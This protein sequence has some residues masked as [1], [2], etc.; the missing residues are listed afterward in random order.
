MAGAVQ[1]TLQLVDRLTA[2]A[3]N[4]QK[5]LELVE[6]TIKRVEAATRLSGGAFGGWAKAGENSA[7]RVDAA[8]KRVQNRVG[9]TQQGFQGLTQMLGTAGFAVAGVGYGV[10]YA[11]KSIVDAAA[12]KQN[13]LLSLRGMMEGDASRAAKLFEDAQRFA[14][15]TPFTTREILDA[16]RQSVA[17]GF[18]PSQAIPL[19]ELAGKLSVGSGKSMDQV[20][21]AF[22]ALRGGD[23]GQ[24]FGV[25]QGFSNLNISRMALKAA[26]LKFGANGE[27]KGTI[28]E[29]INAVSKIINKQ[30]G[31][32]LKEQSS[33]LS[34]LA[35]T[36]ASRPEE[37]FMSLVDSKGSSRAL[38]P[39]Q[40]FM[41]NLAE[42]TDFSKGPGSRI[43]KRF[44]KSM[45]GLFGAV[46]NPLADA[47]GGQKG[48][49]TINRI[50]SKLDDYATWWER[51]G[52][53][54]IA[55]AKGFGEG[56]AAGVNTALIPVKLLGASLDKLDRL[57][58]GEGSGGMGKVLGFMVG[59]GGVAWLANLLSFG[60]I[61]KL[62][63]KGGQMLIGA[64]KTGISRAGQAI[65]GRSWLA[66][67][68]MGS[69]RGGGLLA[70][71]GLK[72]LGPK[73]LGGLKTL[74]PRMLGWL[75]RLAPLAARF[76]PWL[77]RIGALF[78]GL[79]NPIG[80]VVT[81]VT[82]IAGLGAIL[83]RKWEPFRDF[84]DG[85]GDGFRSAADSA[86]RWF[87]SIPSR[88]AGL[89]ATLYETLLPDWVRDGL[90]RIG[91][92]L[93][94]PQ[95]VQQAA[96]AVPTGPQPKTPP[97]T[98]TG[99]NAS[100]SALTGVAER[101]GIDPQ[102]LLAVAFKESA[103]NPAAVNKASG[104]SGL[105][106]FL[107]STARGLGTTAEAVRR[108]SPTEQAPYIERYLRE[109]GVRPGASLEQVYAAVFAGSA[110]KTGRVLYTTADGRAYSDN[111][112]LDL[113]G[114]GKITS[115][116]AAQS[117]GNAWGK[118][119]PTFAPNITINAY[120]QFSPQFAQ[121]VG[122]AA[123]GAVGSSLNLYAIEQG[124]GTPGGG[125]Q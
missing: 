35:S 59:A 7:R 21:E 11:G 78:A 112:G 96:A 34:G 4:A 122:A 43:Q 111:K 115:M 94:T 24:A 52:P 65:L 10:G 88:L 98:P 60:M 123:G 28:Q 2:P 84:I 113:D 42:L 41:A 51:E 13:Q 106:Q 70:A 63:M 53:R 86:V 125:P 117:A 119:A 30:Y 116:E 120:G 72:G 47:T 99:A 110:S 54:V 55:N 50:L 48:V 103:L 6:K 102:A 9:Q 124:V 107:P 16:T 85:L 20:M 12:Y 121:D 49:D 83:Y 57:T 108:M 8:F 69:V 79:S 38:K 64:M 101:L 90:A 58:G 56:L 27:Y 109:A 37:L 3:R 82:A 46:F 40:D 31:S 87:Q 97:L 91:V 114:D 105:I 15:A 80:W 39:L 25:G 74:G 67:T 71:L 36:L 32:A 18:D 5:R 118:A 61:G 92:T 29:G 77:A 19:V 100:V 17:I 95:V 22:A 68:F 26:G 1:W 33:A 73:L 76:A 14:A 89:G 62:G 75:G 44:E 66:R 45:T 81:A 93:P 23:F 104:A